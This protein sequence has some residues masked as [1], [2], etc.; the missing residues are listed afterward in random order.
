MG[1]KKKGTTA[2]TAKNEAKE[3]SVAD[4]IPE[5]VDDAILA[6][7]YEVKAIKE[8]KAA[9]E[10]ELAEREHELEV[11]YQT[12]KQLKDK[13]NELIAEINGLK[14]DIE[15]KAKEIARL[16]QDLT[17][18][19][20]SYQEEK[21]KNKALNKKL[22]KITGL[23]R[24]YALKLFGTGPEDLDELI[25]LFENAPKR[26]KNKSNEDPD[27]TGDG[28]GGSNGSGKGGKGPHKTGTRA[29]QIKDAPTRVVYDFPLGEILAKYKGCKVFVI[30]EEDPICTYRVIPATV[31]IEKRISPILKIVHPDNS[32]E[33]VHLHRERLNYRSDV[34]AELLARFITEKVVNS[35]PINR[36]VNA[37]KDTG[38]R[39]TRSKC[40][41]WVVDYS[42]LMFPQLYRYLLDQLFTYKYIHID[43]TY[44]KDVSAKTNKQFYF[45]MCT[46]ELIKDRPPICLFQYCMDR[47]GE[48][49]REY[50]DHYDGV[51]TVDCYG[52]YQSFAAQFKLLRIATCWVHCRRYFYDVYKLL[53]RKIKKNLKKLLRQ[54]E[55]VLLLLI[56]RIF[57]LDTPAKKLSSEERGKIR[58]ESIAP[59]VDRFF[60]VV[61]YLCNKYEIELTRPGKMEELLNDTTDVE[62]IDD[63]IDVEEAEKADIGSINIEKALK[64]P[65][66]TLSGEKCNLQIFAKDIEVA[67][68]SFD[69]PDEISDALK[70]ALKY[71]GNNEKFFREF[72]NDPN[73]AIDNSRAERCARIFARGRANFFCTRGSNGSEALMYHY[74]LVETARANGA[75]PFYYIKYV[76][77][78]LTP[79]KT[80]SG[81]NTKMKIVPKEELEKM[82]PWS[83]EYKQYEAAQQEAMRNSDFFDSGDVAPWKLRDVK[84]WSTV[85]IDEIK[86]AES[87]SADTDEALVFEK[88][89]H[90]LWN[91]YRLK[92]ERM[93]SA[94]GRLY[95]SK[96][97]DGAEEDCQ[98]TGNERDQSGPA[99]NTGNRAPPGKG[100]GAGQGPPQPN[101]GSGTAPRQSQ[102]GF[103]WIETQTS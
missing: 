27:S 69:K 94:T 66:G 32:I 102:I 12:N 82:T 14:I 58:K 7:L 90:N 73:I 30:G 8:A 86:S 76:F 47:K 9:K 42:V 81:K 15:N 40:T 64:L 93:A 74:S 16:T 67:L 77:E 57:H 48:F 51:A 41:D 29:A 99:A 34:S 54:P 46:G 71:A 95:F 50:L 98:A 85:E 11:S 68:A 35:Q 96:K 26:H 21:K 91:E 87:A 38:I 84:D 4:A 89:E 75:N 2:Q 1:R 52:L 80:G 60:A 101:G 18:T 33:I 17:E 62:S 63:I 53:P 3:P 56:G 10:A 88:S 92:H 65:E 13:N 37:L 55:V 59:I 83:P 36:Q 103:R 20:M 70:K 61:H 22:N 72:L 78:K 39:L 28:T 25:A 31:Y 44:F 24:T 45:M 79:Y 97:K 49:L 6:T 19:A 100:S 5:M 23:L 43:E